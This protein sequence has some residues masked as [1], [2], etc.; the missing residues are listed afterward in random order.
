MKVAIL[1]SNFIPWRGYF[2]LINSVDKF[3]LYDCVQYTKNDWRNRNKI[4][5]KNGVQWITLQAIKPYS[6]CSIDKVLIDKK[7]LLKAIDSL[8]ISYRRAN[9]FS[10]LDDL[11]ISP[12]KQC[13]KNDCLKLSTLNELIIK[14]VAL[15]YNIN[16]EIISSSELDANKLMSNTNKVQR[17]ITIISKYKGNTYLT[18]PSGIDYIDADKDLFK[19]NGIDLCIMKYPKYSRYKQFKSDYIENLSIVDYLAHVGDQVNNL[20]I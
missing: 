6:K 3:I 18:G 2:H 13:I 14:N 7:S 15:F 20:F 16:T 17:L 11:V 8:E 1:Q 19:N 9:T 4:L 10:I 12:M 5:S